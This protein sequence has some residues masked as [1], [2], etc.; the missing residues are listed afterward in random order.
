MKICFRPFGVG[1]EDVDTKDIKENAQKAW[2]KAKRVT[3]QAITVARP[4][5]LHG[6]A[7]A[8]AAGSVV[9]QVLANA[10]ADTADY[11]YKK[12]GQWEAARKFTQMFE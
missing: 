7:T 4:V 8:A 3:V 11:L 10:T 1:F 2:D 6:A 12:S 9:C 5:A